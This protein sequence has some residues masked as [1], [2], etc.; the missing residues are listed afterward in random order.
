MADKKNIKDAVKRKCKGIT[1]GFALVSAVI[2]LYLLM[3][4]SDKDLITLTDAP[5]G[6][7]IETL[8]ET[9]N[10]I[11]ALSQAGST[12]N[13]K[14]TFEGPDALIYKLR[15]SLRMPWG[16]YQD[17]VLDVNRRKSSIHVLADGFSDNDII[18]FRLDGNAL[19]Q[20]VPLDWSGRLELQS[21]LSPTK[22]V[23][24]CIKI[25][26]DMGAVG[27]CHVIPKAAT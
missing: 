2:C 5:Q 3:P 17:I 10:G 18:T 15:M 20:N 9:R 16:D 14:E 4:V 13:T 12:F 11:Q 27:F 1:G 26:G 24:T 6:T 19:Y 21:F 23:R 8:L 25:D 22:R 7:R